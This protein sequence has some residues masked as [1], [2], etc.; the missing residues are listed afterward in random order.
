MRNV[1]PS[2]FL[3]GRP[4]LIESEVRRWLD[5]LG[6]TGYS[7]PGGTPPAAA[8][9]ML[10]GKRCYLSF[11]T[12]L[13]ANLSKVR[14]DATDFITNILKTSHSSVL[15]HSHFNFGI[16]G[17]SRVLTSELNRHRVGANRDEQR[18]DELP[19]EPDISEGSQRFIRFDDIPWWV[20]GMIRDEAGDD[21]ALRRRKELT[22]ALFEKMFAAD[23]AGYKELLDIWR[24]ELLPESPMPRKKA[25]T[26]MFRRIV[27]MGVAS[28]GVWT[29]SVR[30]LRSIFELRCDASAEEEIVLVG[31]QMLKLML[32]F[33][34]ELF[35]DFS[36]VEN[37]SW[38][39]KYHKV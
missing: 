25:L 9:T 32:Q 15:A 11:E 34:P 3:L 14:T 17:V 36:Q 33:E 20:P 18:E 19:D 24:D 27:G 30:A 39:P 37:G 2:V 1:E 13:N 23:E 29:Y 26:S 16:E 22:R 28:G 5:H 10:G 31:V 8:L 4:Q 7:V 12:K 6:A 35:H 21:K 38:K